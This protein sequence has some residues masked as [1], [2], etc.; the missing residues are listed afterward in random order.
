[1]HFGHAAFIETNTQLTPVPL[2]PDIK[3]YLTDDTTRLWQRLQDQTGATDMP[4]PF[5]ASAWA[6]GQALARYILD[7]PNVVKGKQVL[8]FATGSGL[9]AIAASKAGAVH[10][11]AN[12]IDPFAIAAVA[13]N[14]AANRAD[15]HMISGDIIGRDTH[16]DVILAGDIAYE[17]KMADTVTLWLEHLAS[18][19]TRVLI[20]DP[21]RTYLPRD[22]LHSLARYDVP[23][24]KSLEDSEIKITHV[25]RF[26]GEMPS[27]ALSPRSES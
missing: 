8:D 6:G 14:A 24:P 10:V 12:D 7:H 18:R 5:W 15:V 21:G 16:Y 1:V 22:R 11:A 2:R 26:K 19:G 4:L 27:A 23:V 20:G 17:R 3:L 13:L 25:L 9:V